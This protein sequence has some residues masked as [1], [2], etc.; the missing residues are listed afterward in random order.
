[1]SGAIGIDAYKP[2]PFCGNDEDLTVE[3]Q[4]EDA[5]VLCDSDYG[6]G[7]RGPVVNQI[8][9]PLDNQVINAWNSYT[10]DHWIND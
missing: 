5:W 10:E 9:G 4:G 2:C 1:M 7:A 6:C 8:G 3:R